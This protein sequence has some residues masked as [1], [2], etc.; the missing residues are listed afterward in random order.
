MAAAA[1]GWNPIR[2]LDV[3]WRVLVI[4]LVY[5]VLMLP[6]SMA[7]AN[8]SPVVQI[9]A[10]LATG[11]AYALLMLPLARHLPD[12]R[13]ARFL[14]IFLPLYWI[15]T[16]GNIIE[17]LVWTSISRSTLIAGAV[18]LLVPIAAVSGLIAWLLPAGEAPAPAP[19]ISAALRPRPF[20]SWAW[21]VL[22]AGVLFAVALELAGKAWGPVISRYYADPAFTAKYHTFLPPLAIGV[23]DEVFRGVV[24]ALVLLPLLAVLRGRDW[25]SLLLVAAYVALID[26]AIE[27]WLPMLAQPNYPLGFKLAEGVG[28]LG[29]DAIVRGAFIALLL[30]LPALPT[31]RRAA[32]PPG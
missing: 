4:A 1:V 3:G 9:G 27:G 18:Y 6:A 17:A 26:A 25:R 24:F 22:V 32:A 14:A 7:Q 10:S 23:P 30:A 16:L 29:T 31:V 2:T 21:R 28:D 20:F 5:G 8:G 19:T 15:G 12:G 11:A 13:L